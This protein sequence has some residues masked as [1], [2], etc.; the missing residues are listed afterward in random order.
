VGKRDRTRKATHDNTIRCMRFACWISKATGT[1]R[2]FIS[3]LR[4]H[5]LHKSVSVSYYAYIVCL[6]RLKT[7]ANERA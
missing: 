3:F 1:H 5:C 2:I 6:V 4:Q 7:V